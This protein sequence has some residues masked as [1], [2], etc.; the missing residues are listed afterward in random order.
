MVKD[1]KIYGVHVQNIYN[2]LSAFSG[3]AHSYFDQ[4]VEYNYGN[5]DGGTSSGTYT[6]DAYGSALTAPTLST[7]ID[8]LDIVAMNGLCTTWKGH[9]HTYTDRAT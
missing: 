5:L 8:H 1:A 6:M 9:T 2:A 3:H 4:S 7:K